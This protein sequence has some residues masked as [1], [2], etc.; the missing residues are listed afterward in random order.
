MESVSLQQVYEELK[1]IEKRMATK[2]D[3][4]SMLETLSILNNSET[5]TQLAESQKDIDEG[6]T[7]EVKSVHDML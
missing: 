1:N 3:V 7:R 6:K 5:L 2:A 4:K